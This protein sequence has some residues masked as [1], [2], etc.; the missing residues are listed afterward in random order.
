M[1]LKE[2]NVDM[3]KLM[4]NMD[5][6]MFAMPG[7]PG[8]ANMQADVPSQSGTGGG[9]NSNFNPGLNNDLQTIQKMWCEQYADAN[10]RQVNMTCVRV[11][12]YYN[13]GYRRV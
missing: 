7:Y 8:L 10:R 1:K 6:G 5:R 2:N 4:N 11:H 3:N 12:V 13:L 9:M